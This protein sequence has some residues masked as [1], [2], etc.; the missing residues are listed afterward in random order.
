MSI[1]K[2]K[3]CSAYKTPVLY[4]KQLFINVKKNFRNNIEKSEMNKIKG[5]QYTQKSP[6][7]HRLEDMQGAVRWNSIGSLKDAVIACDHRHFGHRDSQMAQQIG[8]SGLSGQL[9]DHTLLGI[10]VG[11]I[12]PQHT[13]QFDPDS[14][15]TPLFKLF[16]PS[17]IRIQK[18][19]PYPHR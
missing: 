15:Q 16:F 11:H 10:V 18:S 19:C 13:E 14:H 7:S 8:H 1:E 2:T 5:M 4:D 17:I 6:S 12:V 3:K 9:S